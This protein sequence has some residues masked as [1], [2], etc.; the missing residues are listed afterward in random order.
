MKI[1]LTLVFCLAMTSIITFADE[2]KSPQGDADRMDRMQ[3]NLGLT[4]QQVAEMRQIRD[5]GG[6]KEEILAVLTKNQLEIMKKRRAEMKR[7]GRKGKRKEPKEYV[8]GD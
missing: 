5:N 7:K 8:E 6:S 1:I 2:V 4:D 3:Q